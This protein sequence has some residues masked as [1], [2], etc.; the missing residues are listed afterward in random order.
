MIRTVL[1]LG[2]LAGLAACS[3]GQPFFPDEND[4]GDGDGD[5]NGGTGGNGTGASVSRSEEEND[6]GGGFV[7]DVRYDRGSD[8]F[9]V[10]NLA[11]DGDNV[12]RRDSDV[13]TLSDPGSRTRYRV[14]E[15]DEVVS[16]PADGDTINQFEYR[17]IYGE[18]RNRTADGEPATSFAIV[19][20]G[21]YVDY[22]FGGFVYER[23]GGVDLPTTGQAV[24]A[25]DYAGL[26][27]FSGT[28]GPGGMEYTTGEARVAV[29]FRDF[30]EG[31]GVRG[32]IGDRRAFDM[33]GNR[34]A[35][36]T[37]EGQL[38]LPDLVFDVGP[39]TVEAN[40]ELS[41][42]LRSYRNTPEGL[43]EYE[44]GTYYAIMSG[45]NAREIV[46]VVVVESS[47]PRF[48]GVNV[49]ETGGFIVYR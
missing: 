23:N 42:G 3:D 12:Y 17:A 18:S 38:Q 41:N 8:T 2:L 32:Q 5:G 48:D 35:T 16:D 15:G 43:Q 40:G 13:P 46:G 39:G 47:D 27:T 14:F 7:E 31:R 4:G 29:D 19:R 21:S 9:F 24:Y 22:G 25:G 1:L 28:N 44:T 36:G 49:Q 33:Q 26:R 10:D 11:F 37:G 30:N 6:A 34:I 45:P 20:T